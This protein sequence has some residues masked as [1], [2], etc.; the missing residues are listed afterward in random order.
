MLISF[1]INDYH[2]PDLCNYLKN[3]VTPRERSYMIRNL[4]RDMVRKQTQE[5]EG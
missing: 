3:N 2:D 4:L 1:R 5:K